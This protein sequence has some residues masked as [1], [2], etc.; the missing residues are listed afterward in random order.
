M[1]TGCDDESRG[2]LATLAMRER[3]RDAYWAARD[4][5][6]DDRLRWRA[7]TFRHLVHLA[8]GERILELGSG[9]GRFTAQLSIVSRG[10]NPI[11]SIQLATTPDATDESESAIARLPRA[12]FDYIIAM[13]LLDERNS[14]WLLQEIIDLLK[15]GGQVVF[16]ESNPWNPVLRLRHLLAGLTRHPD[17][18]RLLDRTRL[19]ELISEIGFIRVFAIH[20]DF[21]YWPLPRQL[22][23]LFRNLSIVLEN[24]PLLQKLAGSILIHMQKPPRFIERDRPSLT[25]HRAL[26]GKVSVVVPCHNE[27]MNIGTL[28]SDLI[29]YYDRYLKEIILVDD[30][31]KDNTRAEIERMTRVDD[32][33]VGIYRSPP[34]GVG[35]ALRD[36]YD[37]A[38]G[39]WVLSMDCDFRHLLPDL[40]DLFDAAVAGCDVAVG[41]RFSRHSVL[42]NYPLGK[43][44]ANRGFHLLARIVLRRGLRDLT[45]NLKLTRRAVLR[46]LDLQENGFAINAETGL[47]PLVAGY[48]VT[49]VPISWINRTPGMGASSF[50]LFGVGGGYWRVLFRLLREDIRRHGSSYPARR[51]A[52]RR[53]G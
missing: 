12:S 37:R 29:A 4:P 13:D 27:E 51:P 31:S 34:N 35:L 21:V 49:E 7:Q 48:A 10:E 14:A 5:I 17:P 45:N 26:W 9:G 32:R 47:Q 52:T 42:L 8:P 39:D 19:Y 36:G 40:R 33:V 2:F 30:N 3:Y 43:I 11:T 41:S 6:L 20:N 28:V 22:V 16:Y 38:T 18:R 46:D 23:W 24:T 50:R 15:P 25:E 1:S 53:P 44:L